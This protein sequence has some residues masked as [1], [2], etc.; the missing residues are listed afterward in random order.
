MRNR[1]L[2]MENKKE[3]EKR[4]RREY[5]TKASVTLYPAAYR[6]YVIEGIE[7]QLE[8]CEK[9]GVTRR[10]LQRWIAKYHWNEMREQYHT[11]KISVYA[12]L[13]KMLYDK[14]N[15]PAFQLDPKS[16]DMITKAIKD[17]AMLEPR[18]DKLSMVLEIMEDLAHYLRI[19][20]IEWF[21]VYQEWLS[22]FLEFA[23]AKYSTK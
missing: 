2:E 19:S 4:Q 6:M 14:V 5:R 17:L 15:D 18:H 23:R 1:R 11:S 13:R 22:G 16:V 21:Q 3:E 12:K 7:N 8:I 10:T 20:K 9:T